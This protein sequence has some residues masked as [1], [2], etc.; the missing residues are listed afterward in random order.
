MSTCWECYCCLGP[1]GCI[2]SISFPSPVISASFNHLFVV[3][4]QAPSF[5]KGQLLN[6]RAPRSMGIF[7]HMPWRSRWSSRHSPQSWSSW[8]SQT[9]AVSDVAKRSWIATAAWTSSST[10]P[11]WRWRDLPIRFSGAWQKIM[12]ANYF[13]PIILTKV[14]W[15]WPSM[16]S[17]VTGLLQEVS[18]V[19]PYIHHFRME[20]LVLFRKIPAFVWWKLSVF[21][22]K[23]WW[24]KRD[25]ES[26]L[27][28]YSYLLLCAVP[29]PSPALYFP[30]LTHIPGSPPI[31]FHVLDHCLHPLQTFYYIHLVVD[32]LLIMTVGP[33]LKFCSQSRRKEFIPNYKRPRIPSIPFQKQESVS[34]VV[35]DSLWPHRL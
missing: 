17:W 11:A 14:S 19:S 2:F 30:F 32:L 27:V 35:A 16:E 33:V 18:V 5:K 31:P 28:V 13:G 7:P 4:P 6:G 9:S 22:Y 3:I 34:S 10:T 23:C 8:I 26:L 29:F 25:Y 1:Q 21:D 20:P 15:V 24:K 12:D